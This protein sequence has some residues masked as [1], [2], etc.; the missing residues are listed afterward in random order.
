MNYRSFFLYAT[1]ALGLSITAPAQT[2]EREDTRSSSERATSYVAHATKPEATSAADQLTPIA[3][4]LSSKQGAQ[5]TWPR[6]PVT[7]YSWDD[8]SETV[9]KFDGR[10]WTVTRKDMRTGAIE[11]FTQSGA[12]ASGRIEFIQ[13]K[14]DASPEALDALQRK[15]FT[16]DGV[17]DAQPAKLASR[18]SVPLPQSMR[19]AVEGTILSAPNPPGDSITN[20]LPDDVRQQMATETRELVDRLNREAS[21]GRAAPKAQLGPT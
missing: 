21:T 2:T 11:R 13:G 7:C 3:I 18:Q 16:W 4:P 19:R 6:E 12:G 15:L 1:S 9:L 8:A 5:A 10:S 20:L 17:E 14:G